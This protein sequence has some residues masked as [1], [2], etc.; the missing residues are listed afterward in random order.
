MNPIPFIVTCRNIARLWER[1]RHTDNA[2]ALAF[3]ALIS[4]APLLLFGVTAAGV[5]LGEKAAHGELERQL[6]AV[7]G[8]DATMIVEGMLQ[9]ARIA[10]RSQPVAFAIA[11]FTLLYAGSHVL[12]K[13]RQSLNL[14][15]E[16]APADPA[17]RW[18]GRLLSR[19][20]CASLILFFG[21]LLIAGSAMEGIAGYVTSQMDSPWVAKFNLQKES[22]WLTTFLLLTFAFTMILKILPRRRPLWRHAFVGAAFGALAAVSLK[23]LLDLYLRHTL[24]ASIIG[25]GLTV[26]L[27]LFWLFLSIQAFLAGAELSAWLGR[28]SGRLIDRREQETP[29]P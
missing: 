20:L 9:S 10:P 25:S 6:N 26:L 23:G 29:L 2:A 14:V 4:L 13:L 7:I 16:A 8:P 3:Y 21:V 24:W 18:L 5:V 17:R 1:H 15:N 27:F 11:M 22:R 19:A 12:T 28:R